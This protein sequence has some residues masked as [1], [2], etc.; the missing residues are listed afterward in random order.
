[1]VKNLQINCTVYKIEK[2][3]IHRLIS[4]LKR[5]FH[6]NISSL[7]INF[8]SSAEITQINKK[9]LRHNY[10]TDIITFNYSGSNDFI[11]GE[12]FISEKDAE[13]NAKKYKAS[14]NEEIL[15]LVIH[16]IL[17]LLGFNDKNRNQKLEMKHYENKL[18][19]KYKNLL[20]AVKRI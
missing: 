8:I 17:H 15:R 4:L 9:Y 13:L 18:L 2:I 1:V 6:F 5:E 12:I 3:I 10:S 16:G 7:N 19:N 14:F 11:E 20:Y